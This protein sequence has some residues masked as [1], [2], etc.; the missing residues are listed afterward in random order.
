MKAT[1]LTLLM[2]GALIGSSTAA[3]DFNDDTFVSGFWNFG[4]EGQGTSGVADQNLAGSGFSGTYSSTGFNTITPSSSDGTFGNG[5]SP[6]D[7][8]PIVN[9]LTGPAAG[10]AVTGNNAFILGLNNVMTFAFTIDPTG[11]GRPGYMGL[12]GLLFDA[13]AF[14]PGTSVQVVSKING[15]QFGATQNFPLTSGFEG[16]INLLGATLPSGGNLTVD[17][18]AL[19][20]FVSLDNIGLAVVPETAGVVS[21]GL[22]MVGGLTLRSRRR[23]IA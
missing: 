5:I 16:T 1:A 2:T 19:G 21:L 9:P 3:L 12:S 18:T 23:S 13:S 15:V 17:F 22:L 8:D 14:S 6:N 10:P 11:T 7:G 4:P 20:G